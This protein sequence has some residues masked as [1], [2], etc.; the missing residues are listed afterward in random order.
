M[1]WLVIFFIS[2][3]PAVFS[4][5]PTPKIVELQKQLDTASTPK[6][7]ADIRG[8]IVMEWRRINPGASIPYA[9]ELIEFCRQTQYVDRE[10]ELYL[11]LAQT[12]DLVGKQDSASLWANYALQMSKKLGDK[13]KEYRAA[14]IVADKILIGHQRPD[15]ALYFLLPYWERLEKETN[16]TLLPQKIK[17]LHTIGSCYHQ[18]N[19]IVEA[20][21][22]LL[23][24]VELAKKHNRTENLFSFYAGLANFLA[25]KMDFKASLEYSRL[26]L[27]TLPVGH[28]NAPGVFNIAANAF[29][30]M[31]Q[32]DSAQWYSN[33]VL[34]ASS[35][36]P[37]RKATAHV[38]L[39]QIAQKQK[40]VYLSIEEA[41]KAII[42]TEQ[43]GDQ[44]GRARA[45]HIQSV[46]LMELRK[47]QE[48]VD[49]LEEVLSFYEKVPGDPWRFERVAVLAALNKA[50][51]LL[52]GKPEI[53]E[54]FEDYVAARD[55]TYDEKLIDKIQTLRHEFEA[56]EKE[57]KI[58]QQDL[59]LK[60]TRK[61]NLLLVVSVCLVLFIAG[62]IWYILRLSKK[63]N[64]M[65]LEQNEALRSANETLIQSIHE[66]SNGNTLQSI[67]ESTLVL[68]NRDKTVLRL[69]DILYLQSQE[70]GV[71]LHTNDARH[72]DWQNMKNYVGVLPDQLF[73]QI[74]RSY[75]VNITEVKAR[76]ANSLILSNGVELPIG[77]RYR[78]Q[79]DRQ[80]PLQR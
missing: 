80:W 70:N 45:M 43:I 22:F 74:H 4:Q 69:G 1:R 75:T 36:S 29:Y 14:S 3:I 54:L 32:L 49:Q 44:R 62:L 8:K 31:N 46:G 59:E 37:Q 57:E 11:L 6:I 30:K 20:V 23:K 52:A 25:E 19:K 13:R 72:W 2:Y 10:F 58:Q 55:T 60:T 24:G 73:L 66:H 51:L 28:V 34:E 63:Q 47:Y 61:I 67:K 48:A 65:L 77:V 26:A 18:S 21:D 15:S 33:Q 78:P 39:A 35:S 9:W 12:Y 79:V 71:Q 50:K 16:D 56:E 17:Y 38:M 76:R 5:T 27:R 68:T 41:Q 64:Q 42:I 40:K 7:Q 53:S